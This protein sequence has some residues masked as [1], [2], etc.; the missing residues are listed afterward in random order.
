MILSW[1]FF[2]LLLPLLLH[3]RRRR[4]IR[5]SVNSH[6]QSVFVT[7]LNDTLTSSNE[8]LHRFC[9]SFRLNLSLKYQP[10][11][12][13]LCCLFNARRQFV[14]VCS[15][16]MAINVICVTMKNERISWRSALQCAL[17][18]GL[19]AKWFYFSS[20]HFAVCCVGKNGSSVDHKQD[21][22]CGTSFHSSWEQKKKN[23]TK[24]D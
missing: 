18:N 24:L 8:Q 13:F 21:V 4:L 6:G 2:P 12:D 1:V 7:K 14:C 22:W 11:N 15:H 5:S 3:H 23:H 16:S 19:A 9:T 10:V 20:S 17:L